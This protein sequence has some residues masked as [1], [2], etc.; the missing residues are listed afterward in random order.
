MGI[1]KSKFIAVFSSL[2]LVLILGT[3]VDTLAQKG[4]H[5][6]HGGGKGNGKGHG[7][8]QGGPP[9]GGPPPG[10]G[11]RKNEQPQPQQIPG[12]ANRP[13]PQPQYQP[14]V[15][16]PQ[17]VI[18]QSKGEWKQAKQEWKQE[19][20][21]A[22]AEQRAWRQQPQVVIDHQRRQ[23]PPPWAG[24]WT[25]PGQIKKAQRMA[26]RQIRVENYAYENDRRRDRRNRQVWQYIAPE[27]PNVYYEQPPV[28]YNDEP[29]YEYYR[30]PRYYGSPVDQY[31]PGGYYGGSSLVNYY[32]SYGGNDLFDLG[33]YYEPDNFSLSDPFLGGVDWKNFLLSTVVNVLFNGGGDDQFFGQSGSPIQSPGGLFG[34][35]LGGLGGYSPVGYADSAYGYAE[36]SYN[37]VGREIY[38]AGY[39]QGFETG[40][41][42]VVNGEEL[43]SL[44]DPYVL[45][46]AGFGYGASALNFD[47]RRTLN[48]GFAQGYQDAFANDNELAANNGGEIDWTSAIVGGLLSLF[49]G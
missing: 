8:N 20:K 9:Q 17:V 14:R 27:Q 7:G 45:D 18:P 46:R 38:D 30:S 35:D 28:A 48:E 15:Y 23:G 24:V 43:A 4:G 10:R 41:R 6:N 47:Q 12:W 32:P 31:V 33:N 13:A 5:G 1:H 21:A 11:W 40:R 39:E 19:R 37:G 26:E 44:D 49:N 36:P 22:K 16:Q 34:Q 25:A 42:A 3:G 2:L 29:R